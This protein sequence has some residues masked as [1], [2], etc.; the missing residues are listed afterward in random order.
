MLRTKNIL[1]YLYKHSFI[2]YLIVGSTTFV[3]DFGILYVLHG[4][5]ELNLAGS[6][7]FAYWISILYNFL[8]NRH[9][10]F[11][12]SEKESLKRHITTYF[13]LLVCNYLF[14]VTFVSLAGEH[15]NYML[16]KALAVFIQM[17]WTYVVYKRY[18]FTMRAT[19]EVSVE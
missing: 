10:T 18:I 15:M 5:F 7:S 4:V 6:A 16:A 9:W 14:T 12:V 8:L 1:L 11:S 13:V 2:R 3:L 19:D 17:M